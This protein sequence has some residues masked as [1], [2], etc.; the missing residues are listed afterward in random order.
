MS[1]G[2]WFHGFERL[3]FA[4]PGGEAVARLGGTR[5]KPSGKYMRSR[6]NASSRSMTSPSP[7]SG[8]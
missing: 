6:W 1:T 2:G 8:M 4:L 5:G 7:S 3:T